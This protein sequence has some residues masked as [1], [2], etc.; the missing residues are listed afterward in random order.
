MIGRPAQ[1]WDQ[2]LPVKTLDHVCIARACEGPGCSGSEA[3][4]YNPDPAD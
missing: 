1:E 4:D 3:N 2:R